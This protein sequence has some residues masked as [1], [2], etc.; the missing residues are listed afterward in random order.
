MI[1][2]RYANWDGENVTAFVLI[3]IGDGRTNQLQ[4]LRLD[5]NRYSRCLSCC[6]RRWPVIQDALDEASID[7]EDLKVW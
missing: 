2:C 1:R 7:T 3:I 5:I 6:W 4:R